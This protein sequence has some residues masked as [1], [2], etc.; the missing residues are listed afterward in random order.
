[1]YVVRG[2]SSQVKSSQVSHHKVSPN[3]TVQSSLD[4]A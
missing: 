4:R 3:N 2:E 1:M